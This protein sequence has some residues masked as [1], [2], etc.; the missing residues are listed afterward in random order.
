MAT[1][2]ALTLLLAPGAWP[3]FPS[4]PVQALAQPVGPTAVAPAAETGESAAS[5]DDSLAERLQNSEA[6]A[7]DALAGGDPPEDPQPQVAERPLP[8][9]EPQS[10]NLLELLLRGRWLM[11]PIGLMSLL[12]VTI[13][14]ERLLGLRQRRVVPAKLIAG[15]QEMAQ[16][17]DAFDPR[18]AYQLCREHPS[19]ASKVVQSMLL[20]VGRPHGEL[21]QS[22]GQ[23][24]QREAMRLYANVRWLNL[25]AA[26]TPLLGL[27]GTVWGMIQAFFQ[28]ANL[29]G[30]DEWNARVI[31]E[32]G[33]RVYLK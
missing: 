6:R 16:R 17:P 15:L 29:P 12:V 2:G 33:G 31:A 5:P 28:T 8:V 18:Q 4:A 19:A 27:L 11:L 20:Q 25:A 7:E 9:Q 26:V 32:Y 30:G 10:I 23:A 24:S 3:P 13:G 1:L 22:I 21:E 14:A